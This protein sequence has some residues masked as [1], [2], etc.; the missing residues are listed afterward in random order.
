MAA[1]EAEA[2]TSK[3]DFPGFEEVNFEHLNADTLTLEDLNS[4]KKQ[5]WLIKVPYHFD[6]SKLSGTNVALNEYITLSL[7][8]D[9]QNSEKKFEIFPSKYKDDNSFGYNIFVPSKEKKTLNVAKEFYGHLDIIEKVSVPKLSYPSAAPPM[10]TEIPNGLKA[11]WKPFGY[12]TPKKMSSSDCSETKAIEKQKMLKR[13]ENDAL[14]NGQNKREREKYKLCESSDTT[15]NDELC[16]DLNDDENGVMKNGK[17]KRKKRKHESG[18]ATITDIFCDGLSG[19][20]KA[21]L[22]N[23]IYKVKKRKLESDYTTTTEVFCD[24]LN[25]DENGLLKNDKYEAKKRKHESA[26]ASSFRGCDD[27]NGKEHGD[28]QNGKCKGKKN[29]SNHATTKAMTDDVHMSTSKTKKKK[30]RE[31]L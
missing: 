24:G 4:K 8:D 5:L 27:V 6:V 28:S 25:G 31:S 21:L 1:K 13:N 18:Y 11:R 14:M 3:N 20:E 2:S 26:Y 19:G 7:K 15:T 29:V 22:E 12:K 10:Y 9:N 16:N 17:Y 30:K 23:G